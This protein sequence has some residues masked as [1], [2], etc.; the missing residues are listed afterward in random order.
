[1]RSRSIGRDT[2]RGERFGD[3][4]PR[5]SEA[6]H[7]LG[8]AALIAGLVEPVLELFVGFVLLVALVALLLVGVRFQGRA[9]PGGLAPGDE[10]TRPDPHLS[11]NRHRGRSDWLAR[12]TDATNARGLLLSVVVV[13]AALCTLVFVGLLQ[14]VLRHQGAVRFD[15]GITR[16]LVE[17]RTE[18][19]NTVIRSITWLGSN[20]A[21]IPLTVAL[22][23]FVGVIRRN[24]WGALLAALALGGADLLYNVIKPVVERPR[25]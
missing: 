18:R 5:D 24:V 12:R 20:S 11:G 1:M 21:L 16:F 23:I 17:H 9:D 15:P 6:V 10:L 25:P 22:V 8:T 19:L 3:A 2:L 13:A 14:D 7:A 4:P